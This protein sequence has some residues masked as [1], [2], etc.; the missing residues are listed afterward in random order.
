MCSLYTPMAP[1]PPVWNDPSGRRGRLYTPLAPPK[2]LPWFIR[3]P[4]GA[5]LAAMGITLV[6]FAFLKIIS[7]LYG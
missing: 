4:W 5:L 3:D 2:P 6:F 7:I 1:P